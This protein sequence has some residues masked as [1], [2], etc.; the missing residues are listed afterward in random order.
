[1]SDLNYTNLLGGQTHLSMGGTH[2][3]VWVKGYPVFSSNI[4][5]TRRSV[6]LNKVGDEIQ[7]HI[8]VNIEGTEKKTI[9]KFL[10][11][12]N[13]ILNPLGYLVKGEAVMRIEQG[14]KF[15][16]QFILNY[17]RKMMSPKDQRIERLQDCVTTMKTTLEAM[18]KELDSLKEANNG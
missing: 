8:T 9:A 14:H 1:M 5:K 12:A 16:L 6:V 13:T 10:K 3:T 18:E 11:R 2:T 4:E 7:V 15:D 17:S